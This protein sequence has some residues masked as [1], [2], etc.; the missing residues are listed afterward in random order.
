MFEVKRPSPGPHR[1][2]P[3]RAHGKISAPRDK[4][5]LWATGHSMAWVLRKIAGRFLPFPRA[6]PWLSSL[7]TRLARTKGARNEQERAFDLDQANYPDL[8]AA[9]D[10]A[11][12]VF[13]MYVRH[14]AAITG[15]ATGLSILELGPG[16]DLGAQILLAEMGNEVTVAEPY[17]VPWNACFHPSV[18]RSLAAMVG[19]SPALEQAA[20]SGDV[21]GHLVRRIAESAENLPSLGDEQFDVVISTAVLEHVRDIGK[22]CAELKRV[23]KRCGYNSHQI[24]LRYHRSFDRPLDHFLMSDEEWIADATAN[25]FD[26]DANAG[27]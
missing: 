14:L 5:R 22:V 10:Y 9:A 25:N 12:L 23:T 21:G 18:Y 13:V 2:E 4:Q 26:G 15:R 7:D 11:R 6:E 27:E 8:D 3:E 19:G 1:P 16:I 20:E 24:D 17:L